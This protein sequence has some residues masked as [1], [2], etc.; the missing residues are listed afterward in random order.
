LT[1]HMEHTL[2]VNEFFVGLSES[3]RRSGSELLEWQNAQECSHW[4]AH[5][6]GYGVLRL[7]GRAS[8]FFLESDRGTMSARDYFGKLSAYYEYRDS[9]SPT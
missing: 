6:D 9:R 2:G 5:P 4:R 3:A 1:R 8:G 7:H